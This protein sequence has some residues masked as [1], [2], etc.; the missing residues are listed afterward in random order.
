M[1]T[2]LQSIR[3]EGKIVFIIMLVVNEG[4]LS[5]QMKQASAGPLSSELDHG[6]VRAARSELFLKSG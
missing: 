6:P 4:K 3:L 2:D 5:C 1:T